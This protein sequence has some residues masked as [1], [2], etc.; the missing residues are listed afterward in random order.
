MVVVAQAGNSGSG[1]GTV[2]SPADYCKAIAV[3]AVDSADV[4]A[5]WSA[6]GPGAVATC[7]D[8]PDLTAPGVNIR[9]ATATSDTSYS[10]WNGTGPA[11]AH[12]AGAV[13]LLLSD[14]LAMTA[15]EVYAVLIG[16]ATDIGTAGFDHTYGYGR[17]DIVAALGTEV[18]EVYDNGSTDPATDSA[19]EM[20]GWVQAD[21]L[22]VAS[23]RLV[24]EAEADWLEITEGSWDGNIGYYLFTDAGGAPQVPHVAAG[25]G[26]ER[27][28][29]DLV[30]APSQYWYRTRFE[31]GTPLALAAASRYWLGLHWAADFTIYGGAYLAF[32]SEQHY[33]FSRESSAGPA[34]PWNVAVSQDRAFRLLG[35]VR[36][37]LFADGFELGDT[38]TWSSAAP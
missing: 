10:T 12:V 1:A 37:M 5:S 23:A 32:S 38:S 15:T 24:T 3:G 30:G 22:Q 31:L 36:V 14:R 27:W 13:A 2:A 25:T 33:G 26:V 8:K 21:D 29:G 19:N 28:T 20:T 34:G 7:A 16:S 4:V 9:S 6:R 11:A 35:P 18:V 17:L